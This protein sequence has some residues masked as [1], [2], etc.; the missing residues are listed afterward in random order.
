MNTSQ[1]NGEISYRQYPWLWHRFIRVVHQRISVRLT[2]VTSSAFIPH[3]NRV[4]NKP[5]QAFFFT[6][7]LDY[8][9]EVQLRH[10]SATQCHSLHEQ[11][12]M[13]TRCTLQGFPVSHGK[14]PLIVVGPAPK[15][16]LPTRSERYQ[17]NALKNL[18]K[19]QNSKVM[20]LVPEVCLYRLHRVRHILTGYH[21]S[22]DDRSE[23]T[24]K[25][26]LRMA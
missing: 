7:F 24:V 23:K 13:L 4:E 14:S 6:A 16:Y 12:G 8:F 25:N 26:D 11:G 1:R 10:S 9:C 18:R 15:P 22:N 3:A 19:D 17:S 2:F 20:S 5:D 21:S